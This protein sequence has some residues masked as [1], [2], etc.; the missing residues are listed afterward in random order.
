MQARDGGDWCKHER[1]RPS[2]ADAW[3][4]LACNSFV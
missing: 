2:I 1:E 4:V 3:I